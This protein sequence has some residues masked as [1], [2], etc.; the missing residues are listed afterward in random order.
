LF[1]S[2]LLYGGQREA[3]QYQAI[4]QQM[5]QHASPIRRTYEKNDTLYVLILYTWYFSRIFYPDS[6]FEYSHAKYIYFIIEHIMLLII[7]SLLFV[8]VVYT[9][10][11]EL[12]D[13]FFNPSY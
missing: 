7:A 13:Q 4:L 11:E 1:S 10:P 6:W 8:M 12:I 2:D 9:P 3:Q 5:R